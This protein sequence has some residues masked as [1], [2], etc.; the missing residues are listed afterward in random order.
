LATGNGALFLIRMEK[1][2]VYFS[3]ESAN[4]SGAPEAGG[5]TTRHSMF[6]GATMIA[7]FLRFVARI[8]RDLEATAYRR[9]KD[10]EQARTGGLPSDDPGAPH[11]TREAGQFPDDAQIKPV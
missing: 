8:G 7:R 3:R 9:L 11:R 5:A 6:G 4:P 1:D 10:L 2:N